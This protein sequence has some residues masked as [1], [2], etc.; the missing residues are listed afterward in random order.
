MRNIIGAALL[1]VTLAACGDDDPSGPSSSADGL[2]LVAQVNQDRAFFSATVT[3]TNTTNASI[4]RTI[5]LACPVGIQLLAVQGGAVVYD[6]STREC[7]AAGNAL[8][9]SAGQTITL[10]SGSRF[11]PTI[12]ETIAPNTYRVRALVR[13][14]DSEQVFVDAGTWRLPSC[15]PEGIG[16]VCD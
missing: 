4:T 10:T 6:E 16:T 9:L 11:I 1:A 2:R 3:V 14:G 15:R 13:F 8:T 12:T 5:S 7:G